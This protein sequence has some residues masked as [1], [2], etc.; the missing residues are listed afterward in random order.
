MRARMRLTVWPLFALL[1]LA[2]AGGAAAQAKTTITVAFWGSDAEYHDIWVPI[3]REFEA[4]NPEIELEL[5][6]VPSGFEAKMITMALGGEAPDVWAANPDDAITFYT[7][8]ITSD[9]GPIIER[10]PTTNL[11]D[12]FPAALD[13]FELNG[14]MT[15]FPN[16]IQ[17]TGVWYNKN[18]FDQAGLAYPKDD[19]TW[20][21]FREA[22]RRMTERPSG[23]AT[24]TQWGTVLPMA[25]QFWMPW[26]YSSGG[27]LVDDLKNPTRTTLTSAETLRAFEFL[28]TLVVEDQVVEPGLGNANPFYEGRVGMYPYY[29]IA[30]RMAAYATYPYNVAAFPAGPAGSVNA[31]LPGGYVMGKTD[32]P[33]EAWKLMKFLATDGAVYF[34]N[35]IP[36]YIPLART[37]DWPSVPVPPDYNRNAWIQGALTGLPQII[38]HPASE[39]IFGIVRGMRE[40]VEGR[41]AIG[42]Q[43][44]SIAAQVQA[45]LDQPAGAQ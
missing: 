11:D 20:D 14:A 39:E 9:V 41:A 1:V 16:I 38:A 12:F 32:H 13:A 19:W 37:N 25:T 28:R 36:A 7:L 15:G 43:A 33:D 6:H 23:T 17:A 18:L 22:A 21:D 8:G 44:E 4:Q 29:A 27:S 45:L 31:L 26:I 24:P 5:L 2:T 10:D 34:S 30:Q 35:G 42:A 40:A 3:K